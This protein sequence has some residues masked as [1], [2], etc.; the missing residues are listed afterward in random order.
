VG[1][2]LAQKMSESMNVSVV[3]ENK[4]GANGTIGVDRVAK[5][6]ADG[7]TLVLGDVGG[8]SMARACTPSCPTT[9][10]R[11]WPRSAWWAAARWC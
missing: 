5:S 4:P 7:Y 8:M 11:T 3:V 10:S 6:P 2:L 1:R 9:R